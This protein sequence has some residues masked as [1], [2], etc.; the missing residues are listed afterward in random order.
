MSKINDLLDNTDEQTR[1][2]MQ[3]ARTMMAANHGLVLDRDP[4]E[5]MREN[6]K[7]LH[8]VAK[9]IKKK[10]GMVRQQTVAKPMVQ[11]VVPPTVEP[12]VQNAPITD[13]NMA[14]QGYDRYMESMMA[15]TAPQPPQSSAQYVETIEDTQPYVQSPQ[16]V[17]AQPD[18]VAEAVQQPQVQVQ[19][20]PRMELSAFTPRPYV[21]API[22]P[23]RPVQPVQQMQPVAPPQVQPVVPPQA[24]VQMPP[25]VQPPQPQ[26]PMA[27]PF[28]V[29]PGQYRFADSQPRKVV[30]QQVH[31]YEA[32]SEIRGLPSTGALYGNPISGQAFKLMDLLMLNDIDSENITTVFNELY[33]RRL[34]GVDPED[35]L[36]CDDPYILHWL[37]ASSFPDQPLPGI[38]WFECPECGQRNEA[39]ANSNGFDVGF[40]NLDFNIVGD[41]KSILAKHAQGYY[42]FRLPDG[43]ECDVYLRRRSHDRM[44]DEAVN[45]YAKDIGK[46][47][48]QY[49]R[50]IIKAAVVLE[51]EECE[52]LN[53]KINYLSNMNVGDATKMFEEINAASLTTVITARLKCPKCGKEVKVFYPFRLDQYISSL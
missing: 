11:T 2:Y 9:I 19:E 7:G 40:Y 32:F 4:A 38:L 16:P 34:R 42:A 44:V 26:Q 27:D 20:Q 33:A 15:R 49:L 30:P 14:S 29:G 53:D 37:R 39:P 5:V 8:E 6:N 50:E 28:G 17:Q 21:Q 23:Q 45:Q 35:I 48:P 47:M 1:T 18:P 24:P 41:V 12:E 36:S 51:I 3:T 43:R 25:P 10:K 31:D 46:P 13:Q 22:Q 52:N